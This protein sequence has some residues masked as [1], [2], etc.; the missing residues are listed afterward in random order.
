M[1]L[2]E[3]YFRV[4]VV[5]MGIMM[6]AVR[7]R[8]RHLTGLRATLPVIRQKP[9]DGIVICVCSVT[10]ITAVVVYAA[11]GRPDGMFA[12]SLPVWLRFVGVALGL[13]AAALTAW[14]DHAL[15]HNLSIMVQI[16]EHHTLVTSGPYRWI[17]HPIYA[18]T[19]LFGTGV[20]LASAN[21][22]VVGCAVLATSLLC[23]TR[24]WREEK[25]MIDQFGDEYREYMKTTGRIIPRLLGGAK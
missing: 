1:V 7:S 13:C 25:M 4:L 12:F 23:G 9:L 10:W 15:S 2:D 16:K 22:F 21:W 3:I 11:F 8:V 18:G 17:R 20:S 6:Y 19:V 24:I 14:A 5:I